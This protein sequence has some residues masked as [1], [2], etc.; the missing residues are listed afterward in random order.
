VRSE[1]GM[2]YGIPLVSDEVDLDISVA[3]E[4]N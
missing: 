2:T 1:F 4:K 3:F